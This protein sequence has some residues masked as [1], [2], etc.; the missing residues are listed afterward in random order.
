VA[1][2]IINKRIYINFSVATTGKWMLLYADYAEGLDPK[3]IKWSKWVMPFSPT[4]I[5][6]SLHPG[7]YHYSLRLADSVQSRVWSVDEL[8]TYDDLDS[9]IQLN[10]ATGLLVLDKYKGWVSFHEQLTFRV[11]G[12]CTLLIQ[13]TGDN[14]AGYYNPVP[15]VVLDANNAFDYSRLTNYPSIKVM[16][17]I[18][19][20]GTVTDQLTINRIDVF[21]KPMWAQE[22]V[23]GPLP[24]GATGT[25]TIPIT[26]QT[27]PQNL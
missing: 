14:L 1:H 11:K 7:D 16:V 25:Q 13:M 18:A 27:G 8:N 22:P 19:N 5:C 26:S 10:I 17:R 12:L 15:I 3:N 4:T 21:C 24:T 20:S 6:M 2:D 9:P 23:Y